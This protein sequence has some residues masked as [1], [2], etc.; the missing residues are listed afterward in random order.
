MLFNTMHLEWNTSAI[1]DSCFSIA[2]LRDFH[3]IVEKYHAHN[4][5]DLVTDLTSV[6]QPQ[7]TYNSPRQHRSHCPPPMAVEL[8]AD[9]VLQNL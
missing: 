4:I 9:I 3:Y 6:M 7:V 5:H 1:S 2:A 8:C